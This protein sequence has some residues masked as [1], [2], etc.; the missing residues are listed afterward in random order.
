MQRRFFIFGLPLAAAGCGAQS[1]WAPDDIVQNAIYQHSGPPMLSLFTVLNTPS[2]S[3]AHTGLMVNASQR[4]IFDPAGSFAH[5]SF[6][7]RNDVIFGITPQ[8]E[9][10]YISYHARI[11]Y[12]VVRQD[13]VVSPAMAEQA[14]H[15]V[16]SNGAVPK[17]AC[18][19]STAAILAQLPG[20]GHIRRSLFPD[21]LMRQFGALPGVVTREYH[22]TDSDDLSQS[23]PQL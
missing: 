13:L 19:R 12:Y 22:E 4:V 10:F 23:Q 6:A 21:K 7:E 14:L 2:E 5:S 11:S 15:L 18:T 20:M 17:A 3:G 8:I 16:M 9:E 1:V